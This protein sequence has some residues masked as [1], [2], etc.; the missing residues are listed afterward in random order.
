MLETFFGTFCVY[1]IYI[2]YMLLELLIFS[3]ICGVVFRYVLRSP[4]WTSIQIYLYGGL[5]L[6]C[7]FILYDTQLIIEKRR[8]G[9]TDF[10]W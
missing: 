4:F 2:V 1:V 7:G 5:L 3:I 9:D 10:V 8:M 6:F